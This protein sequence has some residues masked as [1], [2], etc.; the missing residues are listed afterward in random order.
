MRISDYLLFS[1]YI[2]GKAA[3]GARGQI[4]LMTA[5]YGYS[6]LDFKLLIFPLEKELY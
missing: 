2:H 1:L 4:R 6:G 5:E 3:P